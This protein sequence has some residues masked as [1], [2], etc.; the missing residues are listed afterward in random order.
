L[1][2]EVCVLC[3]YCYLDLVILF[4]DVFLIIKII[5]VEESYVEP[6]PQAEVLQFVE[7]ELRAAADDLDRTATPGRMSKGAALGFLARAYAFQGKHQEV[8]NTTQ[9]IIDLQVYSLFPD[10]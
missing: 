6:S 1:S 8:A 2:V 4:G 10:Y 5:T 3:V 7:E 9:E